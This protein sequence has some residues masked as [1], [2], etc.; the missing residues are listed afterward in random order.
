MLMSAGKLGGERWSL[1]NI[2]RPR[3]AVGQTQVSVPRLGAAPTELPHDEC[4]GTEAILLFGGLA[5]T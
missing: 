2:R 3:D 4:I 1:S 5:M